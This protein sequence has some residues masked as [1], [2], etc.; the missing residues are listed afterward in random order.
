MALAQKDV[1]S[2]HLYPT[3]C[4]N[5][6]QLKTVLNE[7]EEDPMA[8]GLS[9]P[10]IGED[11]VMSLVIFLNSKTN[12]FTIVEKIEENKYCILTLGSNFEPVPE[13]VLKNHR[14]EREQKK[15]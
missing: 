5:E 6:T 4:M 1:L 12:S 13:Q 11:T 2:T 9:R 3:I 8:R 14:Q 7:F 15:L 10:V